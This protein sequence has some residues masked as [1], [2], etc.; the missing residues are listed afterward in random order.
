M[1][2]VAVRE[3][4][5]AKQNILRIVL[6]EAQSPY[7]HYAENPLAEGLNGE[8]HE[9]APDVWRIPQ[10]VDVNRLF[11][12]LYLGG[13]VIYD[14][15]RFCGAK[16]I[17]ALTS[18]DAREISEGMAANEIAVSISAFHDNDPWTIA[19]HSTGVGIGVRS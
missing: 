4:T 10:S 15:P 13:W 5:Y 1:R 8:W 11:D 7:L 19:T 17:S 2:L 14:A 16:G 3:Y 12:W 18:E 9:A 6:C